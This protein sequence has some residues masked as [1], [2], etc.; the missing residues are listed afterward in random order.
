MDTT[1]LCHLF[2]LQISYTL[3]PLP[4]PSINVTPSRFINKIEVI[5]WRLPVFLTSNLPTHL[6]LY[7][8]SITDLFQAYVFQAHQ[9]I[10]SSGSHPLL[11]FQ[12]FCTSNYSVY[13]AS[14]REH[15]LKCKN[16]KYLKIPYPPVM[17]FLCSSPWE[18]IF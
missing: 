15:P 17:P 2:S 11:P 16:K 14:L 7:L 5:Q 10:K 3:C 12:R 6:Y 13:F 9:P 18:T 8:T 1:T 4:K